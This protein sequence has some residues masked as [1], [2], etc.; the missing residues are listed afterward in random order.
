MTADQYAVLGCIFSGA[1]V[2]MLSLSGVMILHG[3]L[4]WPAW[5]QLLGLSPGQ[6]MTGSIVC[7]VAASGLAWVRH[8]QLQQRQRD[9]RV[10]A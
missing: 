5:T 8:E 9:R 6:T 2:G 3:W 1:A 4:A 7:L 10:Q